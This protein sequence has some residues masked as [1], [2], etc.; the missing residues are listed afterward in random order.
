LGADVISVLRVKEL[1]LAELAPVIESSEAEG[2]NFITRLVDEWQ[3][4]ANR[5]EAPGET[6]FRVVRGSQ[7]VG[8]GGLSRM[9]ETTGRV[10]RVYVLPSARRLG[11]GSVLVRAVIASAAVSFDELVLY[12]NDA[13]PFYERLGFERTGLENP[14]HRLI[15]R[16]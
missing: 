12:T 9:S 8:V 2:Y 10:R 16:T 15:L 6:L 1:D 14:T 4:G 13:G 3:S 11:A 5:F 7:L